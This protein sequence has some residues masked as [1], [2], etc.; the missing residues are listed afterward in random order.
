MIMNVVSCLE[1]IDKN[2]SLKNQIVMLKWTAIFL[3]IALV[4]A[5]FGFGGVAEAAASIAKVIFF[6]FIALVVITGIIGFTAINR[7]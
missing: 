4:A 1:D 6:I 5:I 3:V 7:K 2:Y